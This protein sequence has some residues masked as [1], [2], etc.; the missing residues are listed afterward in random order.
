VRGVGAPLLAAAGAALGALAVHLRD[1]HVAGSWGL[2]PF[3]LLSGGLDCPGCGALRAA[4]HLTDGD[5]AAAAS[6]NLL[7]V[8]ALPVVAVGWVLWLRR[9]ATGRPLGRL[10]EWR[11]SPL[12]L[13][14]AVSVV[15]AGFTV[16]RNLPAGSW[17]HS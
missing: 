14:P 17:L 13:V 2:C 3:A 10:R 5:L 6:S 9:A 11:V 8:A 16:L 4:H 12:L 1:P 7:L 15:V